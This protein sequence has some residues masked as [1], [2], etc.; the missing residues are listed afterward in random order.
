MLRNQVQNKCLN[1]TV[2]SASKET[3]RGLRGYMSGPQMGSWL[4]GILEMS[5]QPRHHQSTH[6]LPDPASPKDVNTFSL[7]KKERVYGEDEST[8]PLPSP[9]DG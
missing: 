9:T 7:K 8:G 3:Y 4:V 2:G 1:T 5:S 6:H